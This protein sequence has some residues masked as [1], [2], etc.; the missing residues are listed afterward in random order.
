VAVKA[1]GSLAA[2]DHLRVCVTGEWTHLLETLGL[3][4]T[5][6]E[7]CTSAPRTVG[8]SFRRRLSAGL[9][10]LLERTPGKLWQTTIIAARKK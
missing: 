5:R 4:V 1:P 8:G 9:N 10:M 6:I 2:F 3:T 7:G